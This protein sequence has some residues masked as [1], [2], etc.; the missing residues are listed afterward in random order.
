[1]INGVRNATKKGTNKMNMLD[2]IAELRGGMPEQ[3]DFCG[4]P[5]TKERYPV[6]EE[7]QAWACSECWALWEQQDKEKKAGHGE[8]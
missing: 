3:C 2:L 6:P 8:D 5:Y 1:M 7:A 4:Q